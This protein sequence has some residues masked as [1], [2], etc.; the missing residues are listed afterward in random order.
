MFKKSIYILGILNLCFLII[1]LTISITLNFSFV[2]KNEID[3]LNLVYSTNLSKETLYKNYKYLITYLNSPKSTELSIPDFK[4]SYNGEYHFKQVRLLVH[5]NYIVNIIS[6]FI[7]TL[8]IIYSFKNNLLNK[9]K[10][11]IL[12]I[13]TF[14]ILLLLIFLLDFNWFFNFFHKIL[15]NN[16][17]WI[18]NTSTDPVITMLPEKFFMDI[19]S[20]SLLIYEVICVFIL[21]IIIIPKIIFYRRN[22]KIK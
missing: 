19:F 7:S 9:I 8:F 14:P 5:T 17:Y 11:P 16:S 4:N 3:K 12:I 2:Y 10:R 1:T 15:F 6:L 20:V 22:Y 13:M 21:F 18:F